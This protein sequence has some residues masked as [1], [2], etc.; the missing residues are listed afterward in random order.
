MTL[1]DFED[2]Y[3]PIKFEG[4]DD[5]S[6]ESS[7]RSSSDDEEDEDDLESFEE[8]ES[9]VIKDEDDIISESNMSSVT[10]SASKFSST[11]SRPLLP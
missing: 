11:F 8:T 1:K 4:A 9:K 2:K 6:V 5:D 7:L 10:P 3:G